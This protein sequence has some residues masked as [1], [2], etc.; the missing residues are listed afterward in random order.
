MPQP[1]LTI[2]NPKPPAVR[3]E[4]G[5]LLYFPV[6]PFRL[7]AGNDA[8]FLRELQPL[9]PAPQ[10]AYDPREG[11]LECGRF[12]QANAAERLAGLLREF[13]NAATGWLANELPEYVG[14]WTRDRA[15][16]RGEEEATRRLRL[17][18]RNDLLHVDNFPERPTAGRRLLRLFV[19]LN[20]VE[21]RVWQTSERFPALLT[22]YQRRMRL[23]SLSREEWCTPLNGLQRL[24]Q[25]DLSG[26][27]AYDSFM[28]KLQQFMRG[29]EEF[30]EKAPKRVWQFPPGSA[31]VLFADGL[32]HAVLRGQYALEHS[33]FVP[34]TALAGPELA[35]VNQLVA[36]GQTAQWRR[37][38]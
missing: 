12:T 3:L 13:S 16:W 20:V 17:H 5:E 22:R 6:C 38:G 7:P 8:A 31:W 29:D 37:A 10:I 4:E 25:R 24:L 11:R 18:A 23:P 28:L 15:T 32:S 34:L 9:G 30:Q 36:A 2:W 26:R 14:R 21:P 33:F 27:P 1:A 19:N 35:P